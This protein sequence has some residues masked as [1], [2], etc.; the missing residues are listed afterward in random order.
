MKENSKVRDAAKAAGIPLWRIGQ[1][2]KVSEQTI[3]RWL[4]VKLPEDKEMQMLDAINRLSKKNETS[5]SGG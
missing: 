5:I 2:M 4:R 3:I 1:E